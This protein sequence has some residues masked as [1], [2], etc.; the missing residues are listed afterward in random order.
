MNC[1]VDKTPLK[2]TD[3]EGIKIDYC[4]A[5]RGVWLN[6]GELEKVIERSVYLKE[7]VLDKKH[8]GYPDF[9]SKSTKEGRGFKGPGDSYLGSLFRV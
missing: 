1:P 7:G 2:A 9:P 8:P 5:C 6:R 4:P 3:K